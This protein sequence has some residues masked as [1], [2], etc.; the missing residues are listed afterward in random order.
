MSDLIS[1]TLLVGLGLASLTKDAI[2]KSVEDLV[3]Q[4]KISEAEGRKLVKDLRRRS[5]RARKGLEKHADTAVHNVLANLDV[6]G[7]IV[8]R[9]QGKKPA[10]KRSRKRSKRP[11][12]T[13][14]ASRAGKA[15]KAA[16][17]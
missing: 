7:M 8:D 4:S 14:R 2:Q 5:T 17:R 13:A 15:R 16:K 3:K 12:S 1:R 9:L 6:A 11:R 10:K